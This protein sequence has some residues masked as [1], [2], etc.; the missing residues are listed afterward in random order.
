MKTHA[1]SLPLSDKPWEPPP[2]EFGSLAPL[3]SKPE[4]P[5]RRFRRA[6]ANSVLGWLV[7]LA[8]S[9]AAWAFSVQKGGGGAEWVLPSGLSVAVVDLVGVEVGS[10]YGPADIMA[11]VVHGAENVVGFFSVA[12]PHVQYGCSRAFEAMDAVTVRALD[13]PG[14]R[15][16]LDVVFMVYRGPVT[17]ADRVVF[18]TGGAAF[19]FGAPF[20]SLAAVPGRRPSPS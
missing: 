9:Q 19:P 17:F 8:A 18:G 12:N 4:A 6:L 7:C 3:R 13:R 20:A 14:D 5:G 16:L 15:R 2:E 10:T 1:P 11:R